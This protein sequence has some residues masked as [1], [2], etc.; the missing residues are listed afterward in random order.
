MTA[1]LFDVI[2]PVVD[3]A[4]DG[5]SSRTAGQSRLAVASLNVKWTSHANDE[6]TPF[7]HDGPRHPEASPDD[8]DDGEQTAAP[9]ALQHPGSWRQPTLVSA[10]EMLLAGGS[11]GSEVTPSL[12]CDADRIKKTAALLNGIPTCHL[13][14]DWRH[15]LKKLINVLDPLVRNTRFGPC[16]CPLTPPPQLEDL[17]GSLGSRMFTRLDEDPPEGRP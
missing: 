8:N 3:H 4:S 17:V 11:H 12:A 7:K 2:G 16:L 9:K 15:D 6:G 1:E 13:D 5:A 10:V 14:Q